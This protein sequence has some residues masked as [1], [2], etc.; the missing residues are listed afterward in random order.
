MRPTGSAR[1]GTS[2]ATVARKRRRGSAPTARPCSFAPS[3][4]SAPTTTKARPSSTATTPEAGQLSCVSCNPTGEAPAGS[5]ASSAASAS[6]RFGPKADPLLADLAQPL[7]RRQAR[8]LR[9]PRPAGPRR[10]QR[11]GGCPIEGSRHSSPL[12]PARTSM[13]GRPQGTRLLPEDA[14]GGGCLYLLSTGTELHGSFFADASLS[15]DDAFLATR[16]PAGRPGPRP[17]A[18]HL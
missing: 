12:P 6:R 2:P 5:V 10:H 9:D 7:G 3:D 14:Q 15:G 4:S 18:R 16:R 1:G 13:S 8:L 11:H 17:A